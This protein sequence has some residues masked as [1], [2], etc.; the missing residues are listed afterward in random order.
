MEKLPEEKPPFL[1]TWKN[2]YLLVIGVLA[3]VI[4]LFYI[5]KSIYQF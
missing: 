1:K 5:F 3:A 2:V 4:L